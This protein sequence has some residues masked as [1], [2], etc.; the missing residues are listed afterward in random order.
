MNSAAGTGKGATEKHDLDV[1][2]EGL[3]CK[4]SRTT[5]QVEP[6]YS[7]HAL[8]EW[9]RSICKLALFPT[10]PSTLQFATIAA[11]PSGAANDFS[12]TGRESRS[13]IT[14]KK[15]SESPDASSCGTPNTQASFGSELRNNKL[16]FPSGVGKSS[17]IN[18]LAGDKVAKTSSSAIGCTFESSHHMITINGETVYCTHGRVPAEVAQKN[19]EKLL[20]ELGGANG[21]HLLVYCIRGSAVRKALARNYYIFYS[22]ICRKKVP[23]VAVVTGLENELPSMTDWWTKGEK[24]LARYKMRFDDH[25]C[26]TTRDM[27]QLS[28][29]PLQER[30]E[31][32]QKAVRTLIINNCHRVVSRSTDPNIFDQSGSAGLAVHDQ[33][34]LGQSHTDSFQRLQK[35]CHRRLDGMHFSHQWK[36]VCLPPSWRFSQKG[37]AVTAS[38]VDADLLVFIGTMADANKEKLRKFYSSYGGELCP[39]LVVTDKQSIGAWAEHLSPLGIHPRIVSLDS[40]GHR[41]ELHT[42]IDELCLVRGAAKHRKGS[43]RVLTLSSSLARLHPQNMTFFVRRSPPGSGT[44]FSN[45]P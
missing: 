5:N 27:H 19:L 1:D 12:N 33:I 3:R 18:M 34:W 25:A 44:N 16:Q 31:E 41:E 6:I 15:Q 11:Y 36:T 9:F 13:Q 29:T 32:S 8:G 26:V 17:L 45:N 14:D 24:D 23:I 38:G 2:A 20:R 22:A 39:L 37:T 40:E 28:G 7:N 30:G 43:G 42:V 21:I 35:G 4:Y 10:D